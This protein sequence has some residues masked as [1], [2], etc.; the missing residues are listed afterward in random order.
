MSSNNNAE[1]HGG[2]KV[3]FT[4][5]QISRE[6]VEYVKLSFQ[7]LQDELCDAFSAVA[8]GQTFVNDPWSYD[9]GSGGG[10]TRIWGTRGAA[11]VGASTRDA[12]QYWE[13]GGVGY[14]GIQGTDMPASALAK[15]DVDVRPGTPFTASGVSLVMHPSNPWVPSVHANVRFFHAGD[16]WWFGGGIDVTPYYPIA[17]QVVAFHDLLAALYQQYGADYQLHK[18]TCDE[19]FYLPHRK[20][21]RGVGG[22]FFD[23]LH[24]N[25][26]NFSTT[27]QFVLALG[28]LVADVVRLF[29]VNQYRPFTRAMRDFQLYRR[30]RYV[31]FN[32]L[33]DRGTK[34][35][36][37]SNG[38]TESILMSLP[39]VAHWAYN[40]APQPDS[41]EMYLY[42]YFIVPQPWHCATVGERDVILNRVRVPVQYARF[43]PRATPQ[44]V[45]Y[46]DE[47]LQVTLL[48][49][50]NRTAFALAVVLAAAV[51]AAVGVRLVRASAAN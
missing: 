39:A 11:D 9:K 41:M 25:G 29:A 13:K 7:K 15:W 18:A 40:W 33:F 38:R 14:S 47:Q 17:E 35:G 50:Q 8:H 31:E 12:M 43:K 48:A 49:P 5:Q 32:L 28:R 34:F 51:G 45:A 36:I 30:G 24:L 2:G 4:G 37:V 42:A 26:G 46:D 19:Y 1:S 6:E 22:V 20:E 27:L 21:M 23:N 3:K 44:F 10:R 16:I